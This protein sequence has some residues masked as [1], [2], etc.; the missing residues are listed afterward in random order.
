MYRIVQQE[1]VSAGHPLCC[2]R[3]Q[4]VKGKQ[5]QVLYELVTVSR[6]Y[7]AIVYGTAT[8]EKL[9]LALFYRVILFFGKAA[10]YEDL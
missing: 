2:A 5:V 8:E 6:E 9:E 3:G 4:R 7:A 10:A 1:T